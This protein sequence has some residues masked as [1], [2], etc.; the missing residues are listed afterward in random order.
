MREPITGA[1]LHLEEFMQKI[2]EERAAYQKLLNPT[3]Q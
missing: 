2:S 3:P 1:G